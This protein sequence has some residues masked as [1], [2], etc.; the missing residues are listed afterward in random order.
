MQIKLLVVK[1]EPFSNT[2]KCKLA[3]FSEI[4]R[5]EQT[6]NLAAYLRPYQKNPKRMSWCSY[7][8]CIKLAWLFSYNGI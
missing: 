4:N 8:V 5:G 6:D 2:V 3:R 1:V 7:Y